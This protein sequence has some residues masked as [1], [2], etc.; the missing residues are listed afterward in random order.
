MNNQF[1]FLDFIT[2]VSFIIAI[3]NYNLN[4]IQVKNLDAHLQKQ[5]DV[6][7][8]KII[9]QNELLIAQNN[10]MLRLLNGGRNA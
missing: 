7:L 9:E 4:N 8:Q 1:E 5:D 6:Q 3:K 10:E 2:L